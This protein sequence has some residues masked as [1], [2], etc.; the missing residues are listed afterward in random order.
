MDRSVVCSKDAESIHDHIDD[1]SLELMLKEIYT[2]IA[3]NEYRTLEHQIEY[4]IASMRN[5]KRFSST[6]AKLLFTEILKK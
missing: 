4:L 2:S 6:Y 1:E 3:R 5:S